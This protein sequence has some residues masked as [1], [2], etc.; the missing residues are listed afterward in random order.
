MARR[1]K[2]QQ[3]CHRIRLKDDDGNGELILVEGGK[4]A[5]LSVDVHKGKRLWFS[6]RVL[7]QLAQSILEEMPDIP[8]R[9]K[10]KEASVPPSHAAALKKVLM[11][12]LRWA[13]GDINNHEFRA[14]VIEEASVLKTG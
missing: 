9:R 12:A 1:L 6:G 5:Y 4:L 2:R 3:V 10:K 11:S 7:R 14:I 8:R 13:R